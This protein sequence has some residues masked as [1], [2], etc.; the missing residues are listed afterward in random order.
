[1]QERKIFHPAMFYLLFFASGAAGLIYQS[2]WLRQFTLVL[3]NSLYSA[4]VV[5]S[6]FMFGLAA[7]AW[8]FGRL[9][10]GRVDTLLYYALL[11]LGIGLSGLGVGLLI[12]RI[13]PLSS[14]FFGSLPAWPLLAGFGR[15]VLS[16]ALLLVP[17]LLIGGTLPVLAQYVIRNL[18]YSGRR[19]G[20][21]YGWNTAGALTGCL[22]TGFWLLRLA[23]TRNSLLLAAG[24]NLLIFAVALGLRARRG[25]KARPAE[26]GSERKVRSQVPHS[27]FP[28]VSLPVAAGSPVRYCWHASRSGPAF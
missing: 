8:F 4:T 2:L 23:G 10:R 25:E 14:W 9:V 28:G 15:F 20:A 13:S 21:L 18:E 7:G 17:T 3:G 1:M 5:L 19:V 6:A 12:P 16:F 27:G 11:E 26:N 22:L 24:I